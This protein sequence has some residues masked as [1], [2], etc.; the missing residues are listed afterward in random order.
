MFGMEEKCPASEEKMLKFSIPIQERITVH[1]LDQKLMEM[2][3]WPLL[4]WS[5]PTGSLLRSEDAKT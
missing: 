1:S 2:A 4:F 5:Q 3:I